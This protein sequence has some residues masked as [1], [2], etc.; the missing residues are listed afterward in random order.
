MTCLL[1]ARQLSIGYR[2]SLYSDLNLRL[3][4]GK[5]CCILGRNGCGKSTLLK[6]LLGLLPPR[7]GLVQLMNRDLRQWS[8][9]QM[10]QRVGYVAQ[11][12]SAALATFRVEEVVEMGRRCHLGAYSAPFAK[13]RAIALEALATLQISGL[14]GRLFGELSGGEQQLVML[15]RA[16]AQQAAVLL[17]DE[18]TASLDFG[19]HLRVVEQIHQLRGLGKAVILSTHQPELALKAADEVL[20]LF[21]DGRA[22]RHLPGEVLQSHR[23]AELYDVSPDIVRKH[24]SSTLS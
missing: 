14:Q 19:N 1:E 4:A 18:P 9:V 6:T 22:E 17:L 15:A 7:R 21:A 24:F 12:P 2:S 20:L 5:I 11:S 8:R 10:A 13:D 16:L 23:L 3:D